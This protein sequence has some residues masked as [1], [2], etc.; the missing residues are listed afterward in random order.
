MDSNW[1]SYL[2]VFIQFSS[3]GLIGLT[4]PLVADHPLLMVL[5]L[6]GLAL[7]VWA[8]LAMRIGNFHITPEPLS[9][10]RMVTR[11]PY[12]LIRHPMYLA[13]LLTTLPLI[14]ADFSALR[15]G[16]WILLLSDLVVKMTYEERLLLN[17]YPDY[18]QYQKSTSRLLPGIY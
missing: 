9:W 14:I 5:E 6:A 12:Q 17:R 4:G 7:G 10:S 13:L 18:S 8:V 1:L 16:A 15:L 11:G 3:L 2:F